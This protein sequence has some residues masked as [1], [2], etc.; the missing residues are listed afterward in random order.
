M[1]LFWFTKIKL[2][3]SELNEVPERYYNAVMEKLVEA[4]MY[5]A[6]GNPIAA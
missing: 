4:G 5:D 2:G 3:L 1:V 6:D